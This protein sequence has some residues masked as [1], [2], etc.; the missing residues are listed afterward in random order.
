M[1]KKGRFLAIKVMLGQDRVEI[2]H[3]AQPY[4]E[5]STIAAIGNSLSFLVK[6]QFLE[7]S[8]YFTFFFWKRGREKKNLSL[9]DFRE[10]S[11]KLRLDGFGLFPE[12]VEAFLIVVGGDKCGK[13]KIEAKKKEGEE[14]A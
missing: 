13:D 1:D 3:I 12:L 14:K 10:K 8:E 2:D 5:I 11:S 6:V 4:D 7:E 9:L